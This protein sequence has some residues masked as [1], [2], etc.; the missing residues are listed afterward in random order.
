MA[1]WE[2]LNLWQVRF[3]LYP[4]VNLA[5]FSVHV[6]VRR[7]MKVV[8]RMNLVQTDRQDRPIEEIKIV[9]ART[10]DPNAV[11]EQGEE[12]Y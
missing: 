10:V 2:T 9:R 12:L 3:N 8:Q 11:E 5:Y 7:G 4:F 6:R 1:R